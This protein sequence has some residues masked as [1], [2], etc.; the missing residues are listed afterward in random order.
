[1]LFY[2]GCYSRNYRLQEGDAMGSKIA[3]PEEI[4]RHVQQLVDTIPELIE[5]NAMVNVP[6]PQ[7]QEPD[8]SGCNWDM[9]SFAGARDYDHNIRT[10]LEQAR[11]SYN[12]PDQ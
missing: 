3:S 7:R 8:E 11:Q 9:K 12:L 5:D 2:D 10:L 4:R 1:L 6:L